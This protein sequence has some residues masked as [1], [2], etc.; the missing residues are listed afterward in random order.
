[1]RRELG[2]SSCLMARGLDVNTF[3]IERCS[4]CVS[5]LMARRSGVDSF[6]IVRGP[7]VDSFLMLWGLI[8]SSICSFYKIYISS[9]YNIHDTKYIILYHIYLLSSQVRSI[10]HYSWYF[11]MHIVQSALLTAI[12]WCCLR[13]DE[14]QINKSD[15]HLNL[16]KLIYINWRT[17]V[18]Q[19][20]YHCKIKKYLYK[21]IIP[22]WNIF[23]YIF[24]ANYP[25]VNF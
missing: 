9:V 22:L 15:S 5:F 2:S 1:M 4:E 24:Y 3:L 25:P 13:Q 11:W 23:I 12:T 6:L 7:E 16:L 19:P 8:W 17:S 18:W 10:L 21:I 14:G 20:T